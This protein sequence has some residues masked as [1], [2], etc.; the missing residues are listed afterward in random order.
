MSDF[1]ESARMGS[2]QIKSDLLE[3]SR[4][5]N[6][7]KENKTR[8]SQTLNNSWNFNNSSND[9]SHDDDFE[10]VKNEFNLLNKMFFQRLECHR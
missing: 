7:V 6:I 4:I 3:M 8:T 1:S 5:T 2:Q 10:N 9:E